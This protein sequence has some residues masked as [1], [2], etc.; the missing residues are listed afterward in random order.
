MTC[1]GYYQPGA[2]GV[3]LENLVVVAQAPQRT[4]DSAGADSGFLQFESLTQ[5]PFDRTCIDITLLNEAE[6]RWVDAYHASV[7]ATIQPLV[8]SSAAQWLEQNTCPLSAT[9]S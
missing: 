1:P 4:P 3:R 9:F 8:S 2:F 5:V 6:V 7:K